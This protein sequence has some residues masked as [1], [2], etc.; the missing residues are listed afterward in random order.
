MPTILPKNEK[1]RHSMIKRPI[2]RRP[3]VH[4][5]K[6]SQPAI[7]LHA[8][9]DSAC[10]LPVTV[11]PAVTKAPISIDLAIRRP[12]LREFGEVVLVKL[13]QVRDDMTL[14][15]QNLRH[16]HTIDHDDP[17]PKRWLAQK[18]PNAAVEL[19]PVAGPEPA[20]SPAPRLY[21]AT[22]PRP[23][24]PVAEQPSGQTAEAVMRRDVD[25]DTKHDHS[26]LVGPAV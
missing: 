11:K 3:P 19:A 21:T 25:D 13:H 14:P 2:E 20:L 9:R 12:D 1:L 16:C 22:A 6:P 23:T 10:L 5:D 17:L 24:N 18:R 7:S 15:R 4:Q 8:Q 26:L